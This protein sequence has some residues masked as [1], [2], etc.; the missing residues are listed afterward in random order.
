VTIGKSA[1]FLMIFRIKRPIRTAE[2]TQ[3]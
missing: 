3:R 1:I 2:F